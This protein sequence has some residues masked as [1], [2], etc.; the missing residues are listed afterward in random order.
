MVTIINFLNRLAFSAVILALV[1]L[2]IY[3]RMDGGSP[4]LDKLGLKNRSGLYRGAWDTASGLVFG[5]NPLGQIVYAHADSEGKH[6]CI[7]GGSGTGKTSSILIPSL[8]HFC[9]NF[10]AI[11]ISGDISGAIRKRGSLIY[12]PCEPT[13]IP[14]NVFALIDSLSGNPQA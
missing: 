5:R 14:Y 4:L 3:F 6:V 13:T 9:G 7:I 12:A 11:D 8:L 10:F 1:G 2:G